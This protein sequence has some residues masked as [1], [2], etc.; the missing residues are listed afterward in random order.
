MSRPDHQQ[1]FTLIELMTV[2]AII[3]ILAAIAIPQFTAYRTR[4]FHTEAE[5]LLGTIASCEMRHKLKTGMFVSCPVNPPKPRGEW[6]RNMPE[7]DRIGFRIGGRLT[8]QYEVVANETG[9]VAYARG[10]VAGGEVWEISS[11]NLTPVKR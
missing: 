10:D 1:G 5:I 4:A 3:G 7:W 11:K 6:N 8:Y 2:V 9:F